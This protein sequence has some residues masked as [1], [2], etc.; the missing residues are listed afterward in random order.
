M[1]PL[2][3]ASDLLSELRADIDRAKARILDHLLLRLERAAEPRDLEEID[4]WSAP[5][6]APV[7]EPSPEPL[8]ADEFRALVQPAPAPAPVEDE[9]EIVVVARPTDAPKRPRRR[10]TAPIAS[11]AEPPGP[12]EDPPADDDFG[13]IP[14]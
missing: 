6:T 14:F 8:D 2:D 1:L 11:P 9:E 10:A 7:P 5:P 13:G 4:P 12:V 3:I